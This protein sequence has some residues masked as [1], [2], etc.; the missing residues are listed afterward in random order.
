MVFMRR[1]AGEY[2]AWRVFGGSSYF[3]DVPFLSFSFFHT[4]TWRMRRFIDGCEPKRSS[5]LAEA[6]S[7]SLF[8]LFVH[9]RL[10]RTWGGGVAGNNNLVSLCVS[11][12]SNYTMYLCVL[13][14]DPFE[15]RRGAYIAVILLCNHL[16]PRLS[17][18]FIVVR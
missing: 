5:N 9:P 14:R 3:L 1:Y 4:D 8:Y 6:L 15:S 11:L 10:K 17:R 7:L 13:F 2:E 12:R 16:Y 18:F